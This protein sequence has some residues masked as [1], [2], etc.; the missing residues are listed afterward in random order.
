MGGGT[1][2]RPLS[3]PIG[4]KPRI[5]CARQL[6]EAM[7]VALPRATAARNRYTA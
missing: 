5:N 4:V 3:E 6:R 2:T 1:E 7:F